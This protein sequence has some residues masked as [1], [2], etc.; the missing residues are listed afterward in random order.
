MK[1]N[2][3]NKV[4]LT[5]LRTQFNRLSK[6]RQAEILGMAKALT[7]AQQSEGFDLQTFMREITEKSKTRT[8]GEK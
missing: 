1:K 3:S 8:G 7:Y 5:R 2:M 6:E 4:T